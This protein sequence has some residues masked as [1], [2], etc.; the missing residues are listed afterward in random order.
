VKPHINLVGVH[1]QQQDE[2]GWGDPS[3]G[4]WV[5][6]RPLGINLFMVLI[7]FYFFRANFGTIAMKKNPWQEGKKFCIGGKKHTNVA[8]F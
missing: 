3:H 5:V 7:Y 8:I 4:W 6:M 1:P 2:N